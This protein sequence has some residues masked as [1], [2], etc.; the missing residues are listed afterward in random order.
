M[1]VLRKGMLITWDIINWTCKIGERVISGLV[2]ID[3]ALCPRYN[4]HIC[5]DGYADETDSV[6]FSFTCQ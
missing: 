5:A 4:G 6:S 1:V 2:S 3:L